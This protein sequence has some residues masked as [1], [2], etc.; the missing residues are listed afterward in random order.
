MALNSDYASKNG[1]LA[2]RFP[3]Y[4]SSLFVDEYEFD[5]FKVF[6]QHWLTS[7][8]WSTSKLINKY[9]ILIT[10]TTMAL[11][12]KI[13]RQDYFNNSS[14]LR[15]TSFHL[16]ARFCANLANY[17]LISDEAEDGAAGKGMREEDSV[18][19]MMLYEMARGFADRVISPN[20]R[21]SLLVRIIDACKQEFVSGNHITPLYV[22]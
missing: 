2:S 16:F 12:D 11:L 20:Y 21:N 14:F 19:N 3:F 22:D 7:K 5:R 10:N 18:G 13:K 4:A 8:M 9:Y 6:I 1:V 15:L 17:T